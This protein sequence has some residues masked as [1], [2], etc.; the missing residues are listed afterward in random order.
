[1]YC[2]LL[3][4]NFLSGDAD[5]LGHDLRRT[6]AQWHRRLPQHHTDSQRACATRSRLCQHNLDKN[7]NCHGHATKHQEIERQIS[8]LGRTS[9]SQRRIFWFI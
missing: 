1:M 5:R 2:S 8:A 7:L 9:R 3:T 4:K 6:A